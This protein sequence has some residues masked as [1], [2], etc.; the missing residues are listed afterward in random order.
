METI[1]EAAGLTHVGTHGIRHRAATDIAN[2]G[3][4]LRVGMALTAHKTITSFMR[5]VHIEDDQVRLAA[6]R[7]RNAEPPSL[8]DE[9]H[10]ISLYRPDDLV[11]GG[12]LDAS[13]AEGRYY[14]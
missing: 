5:Y 6:E 9:P 12:T 3:V 13:K 1:I 11:A 10:E 4:P 7:C 8:P 2:S 14:G